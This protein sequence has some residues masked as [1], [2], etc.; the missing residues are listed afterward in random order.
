[1]LA[2]GTAQHSPWETLLMRDGIYLFLTVAFFGV[3][4]AY[5]HGCDA[6]GRHTSEEET[7]S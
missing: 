3:M 1:M 7:R 6:L 5:V 2:A 4:L